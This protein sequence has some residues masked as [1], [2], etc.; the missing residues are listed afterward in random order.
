MLIKYNLRISKHGCFM[1]ILM[2][3][4][5]LFALTSCGTSKTIYAEE[6]LKLCKQSCEMKYSKYNYK[7]L[8]ACK[9][10]CQE[11]FR[12]DVK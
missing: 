4:F 2:P 11:K 12:E 10:K 5:L 6:K 8:S 3:L 1:K 9:S 7:E